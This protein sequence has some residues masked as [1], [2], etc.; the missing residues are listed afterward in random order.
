MIETA[1]I[2]PTRVPYSTSVAPD[3]RRMKALNGDMGKRNLFL[4]YVSP[5]IGNLASGFIAP[6]SET[7]HRQIGPLGAV[8]KSDFGDRIGARCCSFGII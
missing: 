5:K 7:F 1:E 4:V 8:S 6:D 3:L 2:N